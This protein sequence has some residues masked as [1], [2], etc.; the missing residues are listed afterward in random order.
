MLDFPNSPSVGQTFVS[1]NTTWT[2]DGTKWVAA[3]TSG[4]SSIYLPLTGGTL[5]GPLTVSAPTS[6]IDNAI[7]GA[8]TPAAASVTSLNGGPLAGQR[9]MI[10]NGTGRIDQR[11]GNA[12]TTPTVAGGLNYFG[13]RWALVPSQPSKFNVYCGIDPG[14]PIAGTNGLRTTIVAQVASTYTPVAADYF[15]IVQVIEGRNIARLG[16][17]FAGASPVTLSFWANASAAGTYCVALTNGA[18][19]RCYLATYTLAASVWTYVKIT[20]PGDTTGTW[21]TDTTA[22]LVVRFNV[23]YGSSYVGTAGAW[24]GTLILATAGSVNLVANSPAQIN[25]TGVQLE[26]G[27]VATPYEWLSYGTELALC[28]RYYQRYTPSAAQGFQIA[29][30]TTAG[31]AFLVPMAFQSMRASPT[32]TVI[33]TW[34]FSNCS[35]VGITP[36]TGS[37]SLLIYVTATATGV[38]AAYSPANG[39]FDLAA[40]L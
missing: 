25:I 8:T 15:Q 33:G 9:N 36:A 27:S 32:V 12:V 4:A 17:G 2:W 28:Q 21:A 40:E 30:Y 14:V 3:G 13:D 23:G 6:H 1:G 10:I 35:A 34:T 19:N 18:G 29:G 37:N 7:I 22:G 5:T 26:A 24:G 20:I 16:W 39:G 11:Y 38:V 31:N